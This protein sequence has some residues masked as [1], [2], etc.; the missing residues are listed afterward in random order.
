MMKSF[1]RLVGGCLVG[2]ALQATAAELKPGHPDVYP[3]KK[4]D[5][6]WDISSAFLNDPWLWPELWQVNPQIENPHL[7]YPGDLIKLVYVDGK[8]VLT[9]ERGPRTVTYKNGDT[10]KLSPQ[11]RTEQLD[12]VIP[13]IPLEYIQGFLVDN[14]VLTEE[15]ISLS[16]Y[17]LAGDEKHIVM[18]VGD[19]VY[20]R[21]DWSQPHQNYGVFR[22]G[23]TYM[24][25]D[26]KEVLGV[27]ALDLGMARYE[28]AESDVARFKLTKSKEDIRPGDRL[29]PTEERKLDSVFHPRT[30]QSEMKGYIIHVF[31]G[32]RNVSQYDVVVL[33]LGD[34]DGISIG[35]VLAVHGKGETVKDQVTGELVKL[36]DERRGVLM[37]FRTFEKV[38]YGLILRAEAPLQVLDA[39]KNPK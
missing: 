22:K 36:P 30:P 23:P 4:G 9:L 14:R 7:I 8:P 10:I 39:V 35:D 6:L 38:S 5:T 31:S 34:R 21:G 3:V 20:G 11:V 32:V 2:V 16:P 28:S 27:A 29:I 37:V 26:T 33:N 24:D 15:E 25:P 13:A 12:T 17:L 18:G 1:L 19:Y